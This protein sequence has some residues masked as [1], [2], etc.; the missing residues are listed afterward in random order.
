MKENVLKI[1]KYVA[2]ILFIVSMMIDIILENDNDWYKQILFYLAIVLFSL[3]SGIRLV[4]EELEI[5]KGVELI[6]KGKEWN[7]YRLSYRRRVIRMLWIALPLTIY[8]VI[9]S[10]MGVCEVIV[11]WSILFLVL[12]PLVF[13]IYKWKTG[14]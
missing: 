9:L 6:D 12:C 13:N 1:M 10:I 7:Y 14:N 3:Q 2:I 4:S 11:F 5:H 8:C